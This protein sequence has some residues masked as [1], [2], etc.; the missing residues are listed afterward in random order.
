MPPPPAPKTPSPEPKNVGP[1]DAVGKPIPDHLQGVWTRNAEWLK[2]FVGSLQAVARDVRNDAD[3]G[4]ALILDGNHQSIEAALETA[5][6]ALKA[7]IPY[8]VCPYCRA[9]AM[10]SGCR[11]CLGKGMV[12]KF[13]YD[14]AASDEVKG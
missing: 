14:H 4:G 13:K 5:N 8:A 1:T 7:N 3:A 2:D 10:Q 6:A 11:F 9:G 12:G